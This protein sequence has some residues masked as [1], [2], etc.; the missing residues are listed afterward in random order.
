MHALVAA[1]LGDTDLAL[2]YLHAI[3]DF[4]PDPNAAGGVRIANLGGIWQAIVMGLGGLDLIG[5]LPAI[6]PRLPPQ[7]RS[8]AYRARMRGQ[9]LS[10]NVRPAE[11]EVTLIEGNGI[12]VQIAGRR[13]SLAS[14]ESVRV[15]T[16]EPAPA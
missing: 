12:E 3:L 7:W 5:D 9:M 1:R 6:E 10:V 15:T 2:R 4:D 14:G 8:L 11:V 16:R 13:H